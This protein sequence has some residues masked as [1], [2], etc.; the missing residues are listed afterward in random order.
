MY[1]EKDFIEKVFRVLKTQ[2]EVEPVRHRLEHRVCKG[3]FVRVH[4]GVSVIICASVEVERSF[5]QGR[6]VGKC[7]Y[8]EAFL[9]KLFLKV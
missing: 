5:G 7:R 2:E 1:L 6:F 3:V 4:A 8:S 9:I